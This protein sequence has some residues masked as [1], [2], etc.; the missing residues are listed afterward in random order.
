MFRSCGRSYLAR[1]VPPIMIGRFSTG[2]PVMRI[3][4]LDEA[5]VGSVEKD[6]VL[7]VAG[8]LVRADTQW[9]AL[10]S[11]LETVLSDATPAGVRRPRFL[12]AKDIFHGTKEFHR[13]HWSRERRESLLDEIAKIPAQFELP[14]IWSSIDRRTFAVDHPDAN[15]TSLLI[16]AFSVCAMACLLKTEVYMRAQ[17]DK[18]EVASV[19]FEANADV[20]KRIPELWSFVR[21]PGDEEKHLLPGYEV[22]IPPRQIIDAPSYQPKTASSILQLADFCAFAIM[23]HQ[24]RSKGA[25][26]LLGPMIKQMVTFSEGQESHQKA[27]WNADFIKEGPFHTRVA[28]LPSRVPSAR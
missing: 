4:Y 6:P 22:A 2:G 15:P 17:P 7:A 9:V 24:Q 25:D 16:D 13:D 21:N 12:H 23:R 5:G 10:A 1:L 14:I 19:T 26:R 27:W 3:L 8:V 20:Q 18:T 11:H 28:K